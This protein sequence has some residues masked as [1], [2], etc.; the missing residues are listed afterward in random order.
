MG[1]PSQQ[2][3]TFSCL[4]TQRKKGSFTPQTWSLN[5]KN[6][7]DTQSIH[8]WKLSLSNLTQYPQEDL[9]K[10]MVCNKYHISLCGSQL[11]WLSSP[12]GNIMAAEKN[13]E[14]RYFG[15]TKTNSF[16]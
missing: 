7:R 13:F 4:Q 14:Q 12:T 11:S 1:T 15:G 2:R 16:F 5:T 6:W 3:H 8:C 10:I 9:F